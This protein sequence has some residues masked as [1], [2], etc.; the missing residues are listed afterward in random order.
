MKARLQEIAFTAYCWFST[1]VLI[2]AVLIILGFL[3]YR[4]SGAINQD[5]LFGGTDPW[6]A[7]TGARQV[8]DGIYPAV[9]GTVSLVLLSV[10][11][12]LPLGL[13]CGIY[14]AVFANGRLKR[15]LSLLIDVLASVPSIVIGLF[16]LALVIILHKQLSPEIYPS[17]L[18][19][20]IALACLVLPYIVRMTEVAIDG[21][22]APTRLAALALGASRWQN[23][24][25]VLLPK[26]L[27]GVFSGCILAIGRCAEDTAV[28]MLTG[29][30]ASAGMPHSL[31]G[32]YEAVPF[33]IYY[34]SSQYA[35]QHELQQVYGASIVL[36]MVCT[37]LLLGAG[38]IR[39]R[40]RDLAFLRF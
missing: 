4:G 5:L 20:C 14:I 33:F 17:L 21:I 11:L 27:P 19:S 35:N 29:A 23:T 34:T 32:K 2:G 3:L 25:H 24:A 26:A 16:G 36:L 8:F 30:V 31:L 28:I 40:L 37:L 38:L 12:A 13:A 7:L 15:S 6:L 39:R 22:D 9:V 1:A 10:S 18:I